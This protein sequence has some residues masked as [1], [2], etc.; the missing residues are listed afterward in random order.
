LL[1]GPQWKFQLEVSPLYDRA[2]V[3]KVAMGLEK[4]ACYGPHLEMNAK[5]PREN[6]C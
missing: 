3:E 4:I 2:L 6:G 1:L 5:E